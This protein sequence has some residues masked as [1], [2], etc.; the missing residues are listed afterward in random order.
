MPTT[1][2][3]N[4]PKTLSEDGGRRRADVRRDVWTAGIK[5]AIAG[6]FVG[7][8]GFLGARALGALPK[9]LRSPNH[10]ALAC[11]GV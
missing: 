6:I 2:A 5:G 10:F 8:T 7:S 9:K 3:F 1:D 11:F 4:P